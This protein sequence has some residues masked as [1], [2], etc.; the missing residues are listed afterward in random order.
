MKEGFLNNKNVLVS[1][2]D[3]QG[4]VLGLKTNKII[5]NKDKAKELLKEC[6][7]KAIKA[8]AANSFGVL[9]SGGIDSTTIALILKKLGYDFTC[10]SVG[11]DNSKDL[12]GAKDV[13][14]ELRLKLKTK[15]LNLEEVEKAI[16]ETIKILKEPNVVKVGVGAVFYEAMKLAKEDNVKAVFT[17]LGSEEIFAGYERHANANDI[18]KE[19]WQGLLSM[20]ERDLKRDHSIARALGFE[21]KTPFLDKDVIKT[22]M[23]VPGE[24]KISEGYKKYILREV[25][26]DLGLKKEFAFKRKRAAQYGSGFDKAMLKIAKKHGFKYKSEYLMSLV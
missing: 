9:F 8:R 5:D 21:L 4:F 18:N 1:E 14:K 22:A 13:A 2:Q 10:Y 15:T 23:M 25:A 16:H 7:T 20:W 11:I 26:L 24:F 19:C 17:G 3:W 6:L 12:L